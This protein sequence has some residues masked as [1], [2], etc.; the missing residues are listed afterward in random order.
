MTKAE[1]HVGDLSVFGGGSYT[2]CPELTDRLDAFAGPFSQDFI[3]EIVLWKVNRY[4]AMSD[5]LPRLDELRLLK[6]SQHAKARS[7]LADL[8]GTA[9]VR[10]PMAS[11]FLRFANPEV[12]QIIDRHAYRATYG[13]SFEA[14]VKKMSVQDQINLYFS[15]LIRL[16]KL[17][18]ERRFPFREA[19]RILFIFDRNE[20]PPLKETD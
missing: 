3:N 14:A 11:T 12:F 20:N 8:L 1:D 2:Y 6:A 19:D 17:G 4:V 18:G 9:G 10:L 7:L 5:L 15:Y 13:K 16:R